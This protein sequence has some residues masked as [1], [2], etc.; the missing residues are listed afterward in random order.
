M[1]SR[2]DSSCSSGFLIASASFFKKASLA[3]SDAFSPVDL[4]PPFLG[5]LPPEGSAE[6]PPPDGGAGGLP[7]PPPP[8]ASAGVTATSEFGPLT[9][10]FNSWGAAFACS[11]GADFGCAAGV[12]PSV[13]TAD[14]GA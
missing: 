5:V 12:L 1:A 10:I 3:L 9:S 6:P 14:S 2:V 7:A 4:P 11:S 13:E 8:A